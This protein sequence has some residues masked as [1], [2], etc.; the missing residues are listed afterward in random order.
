MPQSLSKIYVHLIFSTKGRVALIPSEMLPDVH[1]YIAATLARTD[2]PALAVGGT[3]D[4]VHVLFV[5]GKQKSVAAVVEELKRTT[6]RWLKRKSPETAFFAWQPGYGAFSVSQ[7]NIDAVRRYIDRQDA[8]HRTRSFN[9]ELREF[10][11]KYGLDY[12][13]RFW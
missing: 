13:P 10:C 7:S 12:D 2:C 3:S 9:E 4:H 6:S 1:A 5:L 11:E 8:H